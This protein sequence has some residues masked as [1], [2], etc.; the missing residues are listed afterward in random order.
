MNALETMLQPLN[1]LIK[2]QLNNENRVTRLEKLYK[3][4]HKTDP[5]KFIE[6]TIEYI[7]QM[8]IYWDHSKHECVI[9]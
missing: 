8:I 5:R 7:Y 1:Q 3:M 9:R 4:T 2:N 6:N